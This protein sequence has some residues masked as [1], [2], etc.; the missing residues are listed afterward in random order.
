MPK[1]LHI[2]ENSHRIYTLCVKRLERKAREYNV[3]FCFMTFVFGLRQKNVLE[4]MHEY[5]NF[6]RP[7][8]SDVC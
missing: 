2:S 4:C 5:F 8:I 7:I 3:K 1:Q 6:F